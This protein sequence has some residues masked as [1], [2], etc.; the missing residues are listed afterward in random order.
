MDSQR[1]HRQRNLFQ[2]MLPLIR[3]FSS[4]HFTHSTAACTG[5]DSLGFQLTTTF[6][7][8]E[9]VCITMWTLSCSHLHP[10]TLMCVFQLHWCCVTACDSPPPPH[11]AH[12]HRC[13]CFTATSSRRCM[14]LPMSTFECDWS[15]STTTSKT[16]PS[17][18][19]SPWYRTG[20]CVCV[21][22][23]VCAHACTT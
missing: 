16:T 13:C 21:L 15:R 9:V 8:C 10:L 18:W 17:L 1:N 4:L 3:R 14:S 5:C 11:P 22:C 6:T 23:G 2:H 19:W 7:L 20:L 12:P